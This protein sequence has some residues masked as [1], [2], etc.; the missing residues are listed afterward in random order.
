MIKADFHIHT[1]FC[2]GKN[3]P[4]EMVQKAISLGMTSI[5]FSVHSYT[6]FD[7]SYCIAK[8]KVT[9]YITEINR[10]KTAY[11]DKIRILC[12]VERDLYAELPEGTYDYTIG[13]AH[14]VKKNGVYY[15]VDESAE[16]LK[17]AISEAWQG[18]AL[19]F[20]ED[21][22][23]SLAG[24][25]QLSPNIIGHIDLITKFD[26]VTPIFDHTHPRYI[27]AAKGAVDAL[28]PLGIPFEINTGA[29]SRGYRTTPYPAPFLLAYIIEQGGKVI[30]SGDVH[31]A[32]GFLCGFDKAET[33]A[34]SLG[35]NGFETL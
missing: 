24:L 35:A 18:D 5:G 15:T 3:T 25:S 7:T 27:A 9:D 32:E 30:L 33:L 20:A 1:T 28:L 14:Y 12:G 10:L 21:Y 13:S 19:A 11:A 22:Y 16:K 4:E 17:E 31:A 8:D 23:A 2:D 29:I 6:D 26:E 34:R